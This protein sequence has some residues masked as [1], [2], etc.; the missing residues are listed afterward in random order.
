MEGTDAAMANALFDPG[1][2]KRGSRFSRSGGGN[3]FVATVTATDGRSVSVNAGFSRMRQFCETIVEKIDARLLPDMLARVHA[4]KEVRFGGV[5]L[6]AQH[7]AWTGQE[8]RPLVT[9]TDLRVLDGQVWIDDGSKR[10]NVGAIP[11]AYALQTTL[12]D[13]KSKIGTT[14]A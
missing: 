13:V 2:L 3:N 5:V 7:L 9:I 1:H 12:R 11:N 8:P 10:I 4:G 14:A 6:N